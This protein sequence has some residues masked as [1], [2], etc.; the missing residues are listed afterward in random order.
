M[1]PPLPAW[2]H[3]PGQDAHP[4]VCLMLPIRAQHRCKR[5]RALPPRSFLVAWAVPLFNIA[6]AVIAA[7]GDI[8]APYTLP[9]LFGLVLLKDIHH[10]ERVL[11]KAIVPISVVL[12]C[13]GLY[14]SIYSM[15]EAFTA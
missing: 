8:A 11:L 7:V 3:L 9:A 15:V 5:V 2:K 1:L 12:A 6:L 4:P 14:A 10:W 13:A